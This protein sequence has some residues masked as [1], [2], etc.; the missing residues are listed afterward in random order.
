MTE[1]ELGKAFWRCNHFLFVL[2]RLNISDL[3]YELDVE[4][5]D[6]FV[7]RVMV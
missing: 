7:K 1:L 3:V 4:D 5:I 6:E 2:R